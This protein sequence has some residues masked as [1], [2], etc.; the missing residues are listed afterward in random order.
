MSLTMLY[1]VEEAT[2]TANNQ[3]EDQ[4]AHHRAH[5]H[6]DNAD[7]EHTSD[8][9]GGGG[10]AAESK[11]NRRRRVQRRSKSP[12]GRMGRSKSFR[13]VIARTR[14]EES[15]VIEEDV[16][17]NPTWDFE[18]GPLYVSRRRNQDQDDALTTNDL[19]E[20]QEFQKRRKERLMMANDDRERIVNWKSVCAFIRANGKRCGE[21]VYQPCGLCQRSLCPAHSRS[22]CPHQFHHEKRLEEGAAAAAAADNDPV[23]LSLIHI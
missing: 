12:V 23:N 13:D 4:D 14:L 7:N 3:Q 21:S 11:T 17:R 22:T 19:L 6:D 18:N 1:V 5:H 20:L 9:G 8:G 2:A 16:T 15:V 10:A